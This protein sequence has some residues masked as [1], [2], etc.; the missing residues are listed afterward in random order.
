M[1]PSPWVWTLSASAAVGAVLVSSW[2]GV[3]RLRERHMRS[4]VT[5]APQAAPQGPQ[6]VAMIFNP[7]KPQVG[8]AKRLVLEATQRAGWPKPLFLET[9]AEDPGS[10]QTRTALDWGA[11]LVLAGGG[12]GTVRA[13][14]EVLKHQKTAMGLLPLGTGNLLARNL[15]LD[16]TDLAGCVRIALFGRQ[17]PIDTGSI[18]IFNDG[19]DGRDGSSNSRDDSGSRHTFLVIA[20]IGLDAEMVE[21]TNDGLKR[22]VG[23]LAYSEAG[24]RRLPGLRKKVSFALD[25]G[26]EQQRWVRSVLFCNCGLLPGGIDLVPG[27]LIDDGVLDVV[28]LS[29]RSILGWAGMAIK[30]L[31]HYHR[32]LPSIDFYRTRNIVVSSS[33]PQQTQLD[34]DAMGPATRVRVSVEPKALFVRVP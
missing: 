33:K 5:E 14:A 2:R 21:S 3:R 27:A 25:G 15:E 26:A 32:N 31:F 6:R 11:D 16:V 7:V 8:E 28:V 30:V 20:G 9:T 17:R 29:P 12:D 19:A 18:E 34:G 10:S 24:V 4:A 1:S 23:W 13:I 22:S